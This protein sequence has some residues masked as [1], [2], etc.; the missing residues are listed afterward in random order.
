MN[1]RIETRAQA[2]AVIVEDG[3]AVGVS[4]VQNGVTRVARAAGEVIVAAGA[5]GSP[6]LLQL[7]GIGPGELLT[8][9]GIGVVLHSPAIGKNLQ[10]HYIASL[11]FRLQRGVPSINSQSRGVALAA[12]VARYV[13]GRSGLLALSAAHVAAFSRSRPDLASPDLQFHVLPAS[14]DMDV[15]A[16]TGAMVLER[17]PGLT[18]AV[19]QL[20]PE[21]RGSVYI[22]SS[23]AFEH[24]VIT[25]NYLS[26]PLDC[27]VLVA[28]MRQAR[29]VTRQPA[30]ADLVTSEVRPGAAA[31]TDEALLDYARASGGSIYHP[32]GTCVMGPG[33]D[34]AVDA[35]LRVRGIADL[36]VVDASIM[37]KITSGNTNA[38][39]IMIAEKASDMILAD[40]RFQTA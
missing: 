13:A 2:T 23:N 25:A 35:Q 3:C 26:D 16:A 36:R 27:N 10:D 19:C 6:Q 24:P 18:F 4:F 29:A 11:L 31:E 38:P 32:V 34:T 20:R 40:R 8:Q 12:Q 39:V 30:L 1:L 17:D 14:M 33:P 37:P 15:L 22:R 5:I 7:S 9:H 21:S 28:G